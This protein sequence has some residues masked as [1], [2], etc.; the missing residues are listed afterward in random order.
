MNTSL[1]TGLTTA[2][3]EQLTRQ[4]HS[5]R[6]STGKGPSVGSILATH[7]FTFFN[8]IFAVLAVV[9]AL[10]GSSIKNMAFLVVVVI[11]TCIGAIQQ[12]RARHAV[13]KLRLV[14]AQK[15]PVLRDGVWAPMRSDLLVLGDIVSFAAGDQLCADGILRKGQ[16]LVNESLLTGEADP[17]PKNP[18]DTLLSGSFVLAGEGCVQ[19]TAVGDDAFAARLAKEA[20]KDPKAAKSEMMASL[21]KVIRYVGIALLPIGIALFCHQYFALGVSLRAG[22]ETTVAALVGMIPEGLYLLTS[23]AM[24]AS[25]LKLSKQ[26]VLVQ[27]LHCIEALARVDVLCVDKTGTIT[28]PEM[29]VE[30]VIPLEDAPVERILANLYG[31]VPPDNDT[32][33]AIAAAFPASGEVWKC[34]DYIPFSSQTKWCG[35]TFAG[36]GT[37]LCGAP[38][39]LLKDRFRELS[40]P[41]GALLEEGFR[42]LLLAEYAAPLGSELLPGA[43]K[44]L[45]LLCLRNPIRPGAREIFSYFREQGVAVKVI[46]G[47]H[48]LAVAQVAE[49]AGIPN[50]RQYVDATTLETKEDYLRAVQTCTVFGRVTPEQ[51]KKLL[52][53]LKAQGHTTAMVG[54]GVNDVLA[55]RGAD[56]SIAMA[57]GAQA[58][59][60]IA[61]MVLLDSDF[62]AMPG[63][64]AEGRR[65]INNIQRSASLFFVKNILSLGL[66]LLTMLTGLAYPFAPF[67]LTLVST[68]TIGVPSFF[69]ALEPNYARVRGRFL[70]TVV[71]QALPGGLTSIA[72]VL[73]AMGFMTSFALP[74]ADVR[75]VCTAILAMVGLL[76]LYRVCRPFNLFRRA[77]WGAMA[78]GLAGSFL[79]FRDFFDLHITRPTSY[80]LL[81]VMLAAALAVFVAMQA[82]FRL[83]D[84]LRR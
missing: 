71:R 38:D 25:C 42:V 55:M 58:A 70:P 37:Y 11:N 65:V 28:Q 54:D 34:T 6:T 7:I 5:N 23:V 63:I 59:R 18:G 40:E 3:A 81:A 27:D 72:V 15:P 66:A 47:D 50:A 12:L 52:S 14:A 62:G 20:K 67:H 60:Q 82:L 13:E 22:A 16:L 30:K 31:T 41:I 57:G 32:A 10:C 39:I 51:K 48:P 46:S 49:R 44:P 24:A 75:S 74:M 45:A 35:G 73:L 9:L 84:R 1:D 21:D 69:L 43:V 68:L 83:F 80:L 56:C 53:A 2:Q 76:V 17:I 8:L 61:Q 19:L 33:R 77:L 29:A 4:G 36:H 26:R 64:V 78:I 79:L